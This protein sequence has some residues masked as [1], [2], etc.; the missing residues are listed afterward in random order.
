MILH[1][2]GA[3]GED[4]DCGNSADHL[5]LSLLLLQL[6]GMPLI[7]LFRACLYITGSMTSPSL[8]EGDSPCKYQDLKNPATAQ[9]TENMQLLA[10]TLLHSSSCAQSVKGSHSQCRGLT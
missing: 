10:A 2:S 1:I 4:L 5:V 9:V 6:I 7:T 3:S 8:P